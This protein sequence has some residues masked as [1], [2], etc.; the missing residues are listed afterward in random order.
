MIGSLYFLDVFCKATDGNFELLLLRALALA[1][2]SRYRHTC[3][4]VRTASQ[5]IHSLGLLVDVD[6][7]SDKHLD[8]RMS[9]SVD[10][11]NYDMLYLYDCLM[12]RRLT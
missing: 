2:H 3:C 7:K 4:R 6:N 1:P 5:T 10:Y 12:T 9:L 11:Y 8:P